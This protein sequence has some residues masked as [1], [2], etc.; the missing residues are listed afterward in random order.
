MVHA[1]ARD[2]R[3]GSCYNLGPMARRL[4]ARPAL[5]A[6]LLASLLLPSLGFEWPGRVYR[7]R[8]ELERAEAKER[9][10]LVRELAGMS[11]SEAEEALLFALEDGELDVRV[12]AAAAAGRVKLRAAVPIL[13]EWLDDKEVAARRAAIAAL[14]ALG[15]RKALPQLVRAL[16]DASAEVRRAAVI[17]LSGLGGAE[18]VTPLIGRLE[19]LDVSVRS[20]AMLALGALRDARAVVPLLGAAGDPSL[21]LR[22]LALQALGMLR[23]LQALPALVRAL[24]DNAESV[25]LAAAAA[26]G[27]LRAPAS[28]RGLQAAL[29]QAEPRLAAALISALASIDDDAARAALLAQ[30]GATPG[31]RRAVIDALL[32]QA[33]LLA[34]KPAPATATLVSALTS[35]VRDARDEQARLAHAAALAAVAEVASIDHELARLVEPLSTAEGEL[36]KDLALALGRGGGEAALMALLEQLGR[37]QDGEVAALLD[38]LDACFARGE[39]DGRA[40]DPLLERLGKA[41]APEAARIAELLGRVKAARAAP[42]LADLLSTSHVKLRLAAAAALG[43][44]GAPEAGPALAALLDSDD[45]ETRFTAAEALRSVADAALLATLLERLAGSGAADRHALLIA[46]GGAAGRLLRQGALPAELAKRTLQ[47]LGARVASRDQPLAERALD[48]VAAFGHPDSLAVLSIALRS[49]ASRLRGAATLALSGLPAD[50]ARPIARYVMQQG[51]PREVVAAVVALGEIGDHRDLLALLKVGLRHHWPVPG[52]V[53]YAV[54]RLAQ[55]GQ[56]R[57]HADQQELCALGSSRE[58]YVRANVAA[59]FAVLGMGGCGEKGPDPLR[60]LSAE[61]TALVRAAAARWTLAA[62]DAG[63]LDAA[64]ANAA[65]ERCRDGDVEGSVRKACEATA[66]APVAREAT[67]VY[68]YAADGTTLLRGALLALRLADGAAYLGYAD[69]NGH[70]RLPSAPRGPI[71]L[72]DPGQAPLESVE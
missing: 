9:V 19:D 8:H 31:L 72:E 2:L 12:E 59:T 21:D 41:Q 37:A 14:G 30:L 36:A 44:I 35:G 52:A 15:E 24:G 34:Q 28:V 20:E 56:L 42:A 64:A 63:K 66:A 23:D 26:L 71:R 55:R 67:D 43:A 27:K 50:R 10:E 3:R 6:L 25:Q 1:G 69:S 7:I 11:A 65:L 29:T 47:T 33:R 39:P 49:P 54:A 45:P 61:H 68:A 48:A 5:R 13:L 22:A 58:P 16:G 46:V 60:W 57:A 53:A 62:R 17:A 51:G 4:R 40:A 70:L 38:G 32:V 18:V